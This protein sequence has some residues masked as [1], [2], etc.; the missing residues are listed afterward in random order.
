MADKGSALILDSGSFACKSGYSGDLTPQF[1]YPAVFGYPRDHAE[2]NVALNYYGTEA[3][4]NASSLVI[5]ELLPDATRP[6]WQLLENYWHNLLFNQF[7][8]DALDC[9]VLTTAPL[10]WSNTDKESCCKLFFENFR[11]PAFLALPTPLAG[12]YSSGR[13]NGLV[14]D[15]GHSRTT[16][17]PILEGQILPHA[18]E[19]CFFGGKHI[20]EFIQSEIGCSREA[21]R[22]L[23]ERTDISVM[24]EGAPETHR[25]E[26][27]QLPDG[28]L[29]AKGRPVFSRAYEGLFVPDKIGLNVPG[30]HEL[31]FISLLK[32]ESEVRRELACNI[33]MTGGNSCFQGF[34][35][36]YQKELSQMVSNILKVKIYSQSDR[37]NSAF[38][39]CGIFA[40]LNDFSGSLIT[41]E[42]F[43]EAGG[44]IVHRKAI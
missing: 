19:R 2:S 14:V 23:K 44:S 36:R 17:T 31:A 5:K 40:S 42:E 29:L 6:N 26:D 37:M 30:L 28:T 41:R 8:L 9:P 32:N 25:N 3:L 21:A 10:G 22:L 35:E 18:S 16:V 13:I 20:T 24:E 39:G 7:E 33:I 34:N 12:I 11:A 43:Q 4:Q 15:A 1:T 27:I 38:A